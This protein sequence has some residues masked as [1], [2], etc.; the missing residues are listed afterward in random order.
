MDINLINNYLKLEYYK[1]LHTNLKKSGNNIQ[2]LTNHIEK[3]VNNSECKENIN[4]NQ[5]TETE[6]KQFFNDE[7]IYKKPWVKLNSIHKILKIKE[8]V[9]NLYIELEEDRNKLKIDLINMIKNKKLTKKEMVIYDDVNGKV[10]SLTSL[11]Y[12][13]GKYYIDE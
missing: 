7:D 8:Y 11:Q 6:L 9:N 10:I 4:V 3:M 12:K 13:N 2:W 5:T 1:S